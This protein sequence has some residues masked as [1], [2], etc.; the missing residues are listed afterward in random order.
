MEHKSMENMVIARSEGCSHVCIDENMLS[1]SLVIKRLKE[2]LESLSPSFPEC[3][4]YRVPAKLRE[5]NERL[6]HLN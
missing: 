1:R 4:I 2:K 3:S 5:G 6:S